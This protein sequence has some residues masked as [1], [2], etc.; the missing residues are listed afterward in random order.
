MSKRL[1]TEEFI[2]KAIIVHGDRYDYSKVEY[3]QNKKKIII[4]CPEHGE[5]MQIPSGHIRGKGC[6]IC[7][8][9]VISTKSEFIEKANII[10]NFKYDYSLIEYKNRHSKILILCP[11]HGGF[12]QKPN[13]HLNKQNCPSCAKGGGF[14]KNKPGYCYYIKF[15]S[16]NNIPLYK[17]GITTIT[18]KR[19]L[20][21]MGIYKEYTPTIL[22]E[23]YFENGI[24]ALRV[25]TCILKA[26]N[27]FK[28]KGEKI[29]V[30]G[31]TE[32]FIKD[33]LGLDQ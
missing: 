9:N 26:Y 6:A 23:L 24:D 21:T 8:N 14:D 10:H 17:I 22:Q 20:Q 15:E 18:T 31:N 12:L 19:R 16:E 3:I 27:K 29:M 7:S 30:N 1:T 5:F 4:I 28:Y 32:L 2:T 33:I 13:N 11:D 25:E